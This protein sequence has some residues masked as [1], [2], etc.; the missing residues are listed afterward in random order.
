M[1][2]SNGSV[3][4][5]WSK[6]VIRGTA[7][8]SVLKDCPSMTRRNV[9]VDPVVFLLWEGDVCHSFCYRNPNTVSP[10]LMLTIKTRI[11]LTISHLNYYSTT[12]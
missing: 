5:G 1:S 3:A 2:H 11:M 9:F 10:S 7:D 8:G 12:L 4:H 6:S